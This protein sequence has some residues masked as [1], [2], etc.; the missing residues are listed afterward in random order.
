MGFGRRG[1]ETLRL[2][3]V[4]QRGRK[5]HLEIIHIV[6][7][8]VSSSRFVFCTDRLTCTAALRFPALSGFRQINSASYKLNNKL[9]HELL[10]TN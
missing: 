10:L 9:V 8:A 2:C 4:V 3:V 7:C 1:G 5:N 6:I